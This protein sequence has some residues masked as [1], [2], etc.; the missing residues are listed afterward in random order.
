MLFRSHVTRDYIDLSQ[1]TLAMVVG[2]LTELGDIYSLMSLD[3]ILAEGTE[4]RDKVY[5]SLVS[6]KL[7]NYSKQVLTQVQ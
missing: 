7:D 5:S 1:D 2:V 4:V 6:I 3:K